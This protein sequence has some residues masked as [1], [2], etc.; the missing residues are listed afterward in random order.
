MFP[1]PGMITE[2]VITGEEAVVEVLIGMIVTGMGRT[3]IIVAGAG[4]AVQVLITIGPE[5][6]AVMMMSAKAE[7]DQLIGID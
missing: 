3:G 7:V 4:A 6:E 2:I 1:G 5:E